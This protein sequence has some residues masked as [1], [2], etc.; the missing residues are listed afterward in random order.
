MKNYL[1]L[2]LCALVGSVGLASTATAD[3]REIPVPNGSFETM[4]TN[5]EADEFVVP[6]M[7]TGA[8]VTNVPI[9]G[10]DWGPNNV[11]VNTLGWYGYVDERGSTP[12]YVFSPMHYTANDFTGFNPV[13]NGRVVVAVNP[14]DNGFGAS[15]LD[16]LAAAGTYT[17][18]WGMGWSVDTA[19]QP[20]VP[21]VNVHLQYSTDNG[22]TWMN[23]SDAST[24]MSNQAEVMAAMSPGDFRNDIYT[25][26][27]VD[28]S[29]AAVGAMLRVIVPCAEA[30]QGGVLDNI[31]LYHSSVADE[32]VRDLEVNNFS[33][34][35]ML[36]VPA[37]T[38]LPN[39]D[40]GEAPLTE[41]DYTEPYLLAANGVTRVPFGGDNWGPNNQQ[42]WTVGWDGTQTNYDFSP[43][44]YTNTDFT[45]GY[46]LENNGFVVQAINPT[47]ALGLSSVN[48]I[49]GEGEFI[50]TWGAGWN[51]GSASFLDVS[52]ALEY[53]VD[54]GVNW[55]PLADASD[56]TSN[57]EALA[58]MIAEG[59]FRNDFQSIYTVGSD[60]AALG[61]MLRLAVTTSAEAD[62]AVGD[63]YRVA[64]VGSDDV[65]TPM[66]PGIFSEFPIITDGYVD[67]ASW[68]GFVFVSDYPWIY[69][70]DLGG[71][72]YASDT[73]N[74]AVGAWIFFP[75]Y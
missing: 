31:R 42:V 55:L 38:P 18:S 29:S 69:V 58:G 51:T 41:A 10:D 11:Q 62:G 63:R 56:T 47:T 66:G 45:S 21:T 71:W 59:E 57:K 74:P 17:L 34:E 65:S 5:N 53:S 7:L 6:Y 64:Y 19:S 60:S 75:R 67:T 20:A 36:A 27:T 49:V 73:G 40:R 43:M 68:M 46:T 37:G 1:S 48:A 22:E 2:P 44:S 72:A 9:G 23:L 8:G 35:Y 12:L 39:V 26:Y 52:V 28:S 25:A 30:E 54:G 32:I 33:M 24:T 4:F 14:N 3:V 70:Y 16:E 61:G 13:V 50:V 15:D